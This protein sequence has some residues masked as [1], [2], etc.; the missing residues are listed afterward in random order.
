M[1]IFRGKYLHH[2]V[3]TFH[4]AMDILWDE[5]ADHSGVS[6]VHK[7]DQIGNIRKEGF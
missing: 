7:L 6:E 3:L 5:V 4:K 2:L 1:W